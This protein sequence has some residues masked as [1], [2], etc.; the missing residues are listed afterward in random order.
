MDK[1]R[2]YFGDN[3]DI[4]KDLHQQ[5]PKGLIDLIY[6]D[7]PFNSKRNYNILFENIDMEDTKAQKEAFADT[8]TNVN[9][10]DELNEIQNLDLNVYRFLKAI[11]EINISKGA[12]SYLTIMAIRLW[13][14]HKLLKDTG[15]FYLHCDPAMSHYLKL[16]CDLIFGEKNFRNEIIWN[17]STNTGSSKG[18]AKRFPTDHDVIFLYFKNKNVAFFN[19]LHKSYSD[20]YIKHYYIYDD[21]DGKGKYQVQALK[22]FSKERLEQ[23]E[24]E[25]RIV[26]GKGRFLRFKDYLVD[27]KGIPQNDLWI[28]IEPVNPIAKEKLGYPTQK[29]EALLDRIISASTNEGDLVADFFCGC[30]TAIAVAEKLNRKWLGVDISHL[31]VKLITK[32]LIDAYGPEIRKTFEIF[33]F[34]RDLDSARELAIGSNGGRLKFEE[35]II[36]VMLHGVLNPNRTQTGYDGYMTLDVQG[37]RSTVLIEV[38]SGNAN[39]TQLNHFIQTIENKN[40]QMG[41]FC[42]FSDQVTAGMQKAA[43]QQGYF[44]QDQ[45]GS[46]YDRIQIITVEDLLDHKLPNIPFSIKGTFKT[47]QKETKEKDTQQKMF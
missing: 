21:N 40:A 42:C 45:F 46:Q 1:N 31:A 5:Y 24:K 11:E 13:Y 26:K 27:K 20:D 38:K 4:L 35:W 9:Y 39:L 28:D 17:R 33:G 25:N 29:P 44:N 2:L 16:V 47:A 23:L 8:W 41:L 43:K 36:E 30:G 19:P 32:R 7:P 10:I 37:A 3:L 18:I 34:P 22:T 15:S 14:M 12:V 6:I